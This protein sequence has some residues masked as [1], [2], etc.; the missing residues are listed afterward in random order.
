M[1][2]FR[3]DARSFADSARCLIPADGFFEF[4]DPEAE[5]KKKTRWR[6]RLAGAP[7]FWGAG[8]VKDG[9]FP[10]LTT[11]PGL[12][13]AP[14]HDRQI[15]VLR[16]EEGAAWLHLR[17]PEAEFLRALPAGSLDVEKIFPVAA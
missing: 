6:F 4:T 1:F 10:M 16:P 13:I 8:I 11:G 2:N 9:A 3:S 12:D 14:Y 7:L 5:Q 15:V 17:R